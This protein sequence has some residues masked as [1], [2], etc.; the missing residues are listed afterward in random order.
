MLS[1]AQIAFIFAHNWL[2][3]T[4]AALAI[5]GLILVSAIGQSWSPLAVSWIEKAPP[6]YWA[7]LMH[8]SQFV[9][10]SSLAYLAL[11]LFRT[12][13]AVER[14]IYGFFAPLGATRGERAGGVDDLRAVAEGTGEFDRLLTLMD[15]HDL[16]ALRAVWI[17]DIAP[18]PS[19]GGPPGA[20]DRSTLKERISETI[21]QARRRGWFTKGRGRFYIRPFHPG[22]D[23]V[24]VS[25]ALFM[26]FWVHLM[27]SI[28]AVM[29]PAPMWMPVFALAPAARLTFMCALVGLGVLWPLRYVFIGRQLLDD[30]EAIAEKA[31]EQLVKCRARADAQRRQD[32][33]VAA[34]G[35]EALLA[36]IVRGASPTTVAPTAP[37]ARAQPKSPAPELA[38]NEDKPTSVPPAAKRKRRPKAT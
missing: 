17:S 32:I 2:R 18:L 34:D 9:V 8:L 30:I 27:A 33:T 4:I 7:G 38:R 13:G 20:V 6:G 36:E 37:T 3:C 35:L 31:A 14:R 16:C 1:T 26:A 19:D 29:A 12:S 21:A 25:L 28:E 24:L 15:L 23:T 22:A 11:E 5:S 10:V